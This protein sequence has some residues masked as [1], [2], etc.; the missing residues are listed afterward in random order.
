MPRSTRKKFPNRRHSGY[1]V[2]HAASRSEGSTPN[3]AG[4]HER[5]ATPERPT[6]LSVLEDRETHLPTPVPTSPAPTTPAQTSPAPRTPAQTSPAPA[7]PVPTSFVSTTPVRTSLLSATP[8]PTSAAPRTPVPTT[9]AP[10]PTIVPETP[11][12]ALTEGAAQAGEQQD[13]GPLPLDVDLLGKNSHFYLVVHLFF[14]CV[15]T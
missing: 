15:L 8:A 13:A 10:A 3:A 6:E 12:A 7:T 2:T 14:S 4:S 1:I 11:N 5:A 9:A